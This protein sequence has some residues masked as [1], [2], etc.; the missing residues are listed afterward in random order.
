MHS[1]QRESLILEHLDAQSFM[2]F[3]ELE[4]KIDASP[5]TLRRD[6]HRLAEQGRLKRVRGGVIANGE[7]SSAPLVSAPAANG[8]TFRL[9]G[10]TFADNLPLANDEK[11]RIA[12]KAAELCQAGE[13][14]MIDGGTTTFHMCSHL[15][16]RNLQVLTNSLHI[17]LSLIG[18]QGTRVLVPSGAVFPE[19][20]IILSI[21]GEDGMPNFHAGKLFMGCSSIGPKGIMQLDVV[22]VASERRLIEKADQIIIVADSRKFTAPSGHVVCGLEAIDIVITDDG[23]DADARA[24]LADN[25]VQL[26]I[27]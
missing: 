16:G 25:G 13:G 15:D 3:R 5:A 11:K 23:I 24:M 10:T 21:F 20:N 4:K 2:S 22:L 12:A 26:I 1:A 7:A 18:Q 6:L 17:A 14:V 27:A 19:Q 9:G 8:E